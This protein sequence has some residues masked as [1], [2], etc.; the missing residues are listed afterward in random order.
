MAAGLSWLITGIATNLQLLS[1]T[2]DGVHTRM[3][4][5]PIRTSVGLGS[6]MRILDGPPTTMGVGSASVIAVGSGSPA[7]N[8]VLRGF[9]GERVETTSDGHLCRL[10]VLTSSS[11]KARRSPDTST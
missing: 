2:S 10:V 4:T 7:A 5:G 11:T 3:V 6:L 8:G 1:Q 9:P